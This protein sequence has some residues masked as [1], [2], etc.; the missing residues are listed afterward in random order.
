MIL[1]YGDQYDE[2]HKYYKY[3]KFKYFNSKKCIL[4]FIF[5]VEMKRNENSF[6]I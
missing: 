3:H 6:M 5:V 2:Y 1:N 4:I